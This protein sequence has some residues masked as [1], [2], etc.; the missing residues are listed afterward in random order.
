MKYVGNVQSQANAEVYA[1]ASGTLP[2]GKPIVVNADG[3][4][5]VVSGTDQ[6][7]G[8]PTSFNSSGA[9]INSVF[10]PD[11]NKVVITFQNGGD[12]SHGYAIVGTISG[13][14]V[15]FGTAVEFVNAIAG[16]PR[17]CYDT[18]SNKIVVI[19]TDYGN[20]YYPTARVGTVSGTNISF[21]TAVVY[22]SSGQS[23]NHSI[24]FDSNANKVVIGF[25]DNTNS[26]RGTAVVGTVS[27]TNISFGTAVVFASADTNAIHTTFDSTANKVIFIYR[28][29]PD[30][31]KGKAIVGTVSGTGISFGS[32]ATYAN[33]STVNY[34]VVLYNSDSNKTLIVYPSAVSPYYTVA[35]VGTISGTNIS[36]GTSV[37][38]GTTSGV[39]RRCLR[40]GNCI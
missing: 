3:T 28:D 27:G 31:Q 30:S 8:S 26:V 14:S 37:N 29:Q 7:L 1:T 34:H 15:T 32:E 22:K 33:S 23:Q 9:I 35:V 19:Y 16:D 10:D 25:G 39:K 20:S 5:S 36:F 18:N 24:V 17:I 40:F 6:A 38:I 4:V 11:N 21:G 2:N 13:T 12:S